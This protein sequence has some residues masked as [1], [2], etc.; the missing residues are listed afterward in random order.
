[1]LALREYAVPVISGVSVTIV[2]FVPMMFLPGILGKFLAYIPITIFGVLASGLVLALTVNSALYL[3]FV[4]RSKTY[5]ESDTTLEYATPDEHELLSLE[6]EGKTKIATSEAP[7]RTRVIHACIEW[8]K[9]VLR[10]FLEHTYL[11]RISIFLPFILFILSIVFLAPRVGFEL[12]PGDDNNL[13]TFA[14]E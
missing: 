1:M 4:R 6:R 9:L 14:I 3:L 7:L 10:N 11:R 13:T 5:V 2:V 12:F 8:Y